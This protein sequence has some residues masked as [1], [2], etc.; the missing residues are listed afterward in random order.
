MKMTDDAVVV[1]G[2]LRAMAAQIRSDARATPY[3]TSDEDA[4]LLERA[5]ELLDN[6]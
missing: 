5:A 6:G 1:A 4:A 3:P 2:R